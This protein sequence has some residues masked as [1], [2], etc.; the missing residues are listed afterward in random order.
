VQLTAWLCQQYHLDLDHI[1]GHK[2]AAQGQT[3]CPGTDFYRYL[4]D[5]QFRKWVK[6]TLDSGH[7]DVE[8]APPLAD[9][10][11]ISILDTKPPTTK[12]AKAE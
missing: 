2:D 8:L 12:P 5:G 9:G 4:E 3:T 7:P 10:P 6:E 1:R 11:T